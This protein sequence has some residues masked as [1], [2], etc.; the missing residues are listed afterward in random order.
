MGIGG[1][2]FGVAL[3]FLLWFLTLR[4]TDVTAE[5]LNLPFLA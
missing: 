3:L 1:L 2:L 5:L 4:Q